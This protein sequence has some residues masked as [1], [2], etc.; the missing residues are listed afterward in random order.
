MALDAPFNG[1]RHS[2]S[3]KAQRGCTN[4]WS[5]QFK[6][7]QCDFEALPQF[8][9]QAVRGDA[10]IRECPSSHG[11]GRQDRTSQPMLPSSP[12]IANA[13]IPPAPACPSI[14]AKTTYRSAKPQFE[15]QV[16]RPLIT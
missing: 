2:A 13:A 1:F 12:S 5:E 8:A 15:V 10:A 9:D 6:H 14:R 7:V 4:R 11:V 16:L 3:R